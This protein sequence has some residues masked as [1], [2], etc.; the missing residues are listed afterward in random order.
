MQP[1]P[2]ETSTQFTSFSTASPTN[3]SQYGSYD[4]SLDPAGSHREQLQESS[5]ATVSTSPERGGPLESQVRR[6]SVS[7]RNTPLKASAQRISDY[8]NALS[9]AL[10]KVDWEGPGFKVIK[11]K[12]HRLD[13]PQIERFPNGRP[14]DTQ[15]L[16]HITYNKQRF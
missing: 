13:A 9:P 15:I 3:A 12:G 4:D 5:S 8:E 6:L 2:T 16:D 7:S 1:E 14:A 11:K 10:G